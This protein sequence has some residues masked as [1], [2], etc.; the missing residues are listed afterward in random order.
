MLLRKLHAAASIENEK[1][2]VDKLAHQ[3]SVLDEPVLDEVD[4]TPDSGDAEGQ[5]IEELTS[6]LAEGVRQNDC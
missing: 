5:T 3:M 1:F 6:L 2:W 4:S